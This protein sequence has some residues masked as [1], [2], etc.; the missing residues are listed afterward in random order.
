MY[1]A[2]AV[3]ILYAFDLYK[4]IYVRFLISAILLISVNVFHVMSS[5]IF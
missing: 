4:I 3:V 5:Y 2:K 1:H